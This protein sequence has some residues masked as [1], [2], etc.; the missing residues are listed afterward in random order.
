MIASANDLTPAN[1][2]T[3]CNGL[4]FKAI[5]RAVNRSHGRNMILDC[6]VIFKK[7]MMILSKQ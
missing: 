4:V 6:F 3:S 1:D 7:F 2:L 5:A